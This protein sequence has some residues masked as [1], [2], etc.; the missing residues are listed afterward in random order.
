MYK[1]Y[2][3][4]ENMISE[5][6][7]ISQYYFGKQNKKCDICKTAKFKL[8]DRKHEEFDLLMDEKCRMHLLNSKALYFD[9]P[10][11]LLSQ[12]LMLHFTNE[13]NQEISEVIED[14]YNCLN[15][16]KRNMQKETKKLT[17]GYFKV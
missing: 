7:P 10:Q 14:Y 4:I 6:C 15:D 9:Q 8:I 16:K 17:F 11:R 12:G 3:K 13:T 1:V 5:Y 2:G